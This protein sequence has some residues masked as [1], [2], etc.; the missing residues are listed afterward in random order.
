MIEFEYQLRTPGTDEEWL[1]YHAIRRKVLFENRGKDAYIQ[2]HPDDFKSGNHPL[3]L[4]YQRDVIGVVRVDVSESEAW[5]RRVAI[6]EDLQR[7]GHGRVLLRLAEKFALTKNCREVRT[8]AAMESVE[9][10]EHCGYVRDL[11][12]VGPVNSVA[13]RK[14]LLSS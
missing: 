3:I 11:A 12:N 4:L 7:Q 9:F 13:M 10:Y 5:L 14:S 8:N 1:A 2:N 6:R